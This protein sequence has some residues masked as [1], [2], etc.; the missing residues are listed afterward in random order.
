LKLKQKW[1]ETQQ[2]KERDSNVSV[3]SSSRSFFSEISTNPIN[4]QQRPSNIEG[5]RETDR[6]GERMTEDEAQKKEP[7]DEEEEEKERELVPGK[8]CFNTKKFVILLVSDIA[9]LL[10]FGTIFPPLALIICMSIIIDSSM[11]QMS[12][13]RALS[14]STAIISNLRV[15]N[16]QKHETSMISPSSPSRPD[17]ISSRSSRISTWLATMKK[18][19]E[20]SQSVDEQGDIKIQNGMKTEHVV[21]TSKPSYVH[22]TYHDVLLVKCINNLAVIIRECNMIDS[23]L[24]RSIS[25]VIIIAA[26][27]W[28]FFLFD[29]YG[30]VSPFPHAFWVLMVMAS[31][32]IVIWLVRFYLTE[33]MKKQFTG[34]KDVGVRSKPTVTSTS[35]D[36]VE[37]EL[38]TMKP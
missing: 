20:S 37:I 30:D 32:P 15:Y 17:S 38:T 34:K 9:M 1:R 23:L 19:Q 28:S 25:S 14:I 10:T 8:N 33:R 26:A 11:S 16:P 36:E 2:D 22:I 27:F 21:D 18:K 7:E 31:T 4:Q 5:M 29:I 24:N 35:S 6:D 12:L 13:Y 3:R